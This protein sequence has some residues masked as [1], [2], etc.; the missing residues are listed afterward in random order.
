MAPPLY[1]SRRSRVDQTNSD[2]KYY[3]FYNIKKTKLSARYPFLPKKQIERKIKHLWERASAE[4]RAVLCLTSSG[5][6]SPFKG[7]ILQGL[8]KKKLPLEHIIFNSAPI[9]NSTPT[10][11]MAGSGP[12]RTL[13]SSMKDPWSQTSRKQTLRSSSKKLVSTRRVSF[14]FDQSPLL[15]RPNT[16]SSIKEQKSEER[17]VENKK[18]KKHKSTKDGH[19]RKRELSFEEKQMYEFQD[20]GSKSW[21]HSVGKA[22]VEAGR[23]SHSNPG[24]KDHV[25]APE[26]YNIEISANT[27]IFTDDSQSPTITPEQ[28]LPDTTLNDKSSQNLGKKTKTSIRRNAKSLKNSNRRLQK[29]KDVK[30]NP[31]IGEKGKKDDDP[32]T[33]DDL[34]SSQSDDAGEVPWLVS[35]H[36]DSS[37]DDARDDSSDD[38]DQDAFYDYYHKSSSESSAPTVPSLSQESDDAGPSENNTMFSWNGACFTKKT[39]SLGTDTFDSQLS[40]VSMDAAEVMS[41]SST[42]ASLSPDSPQFIFGLPRK[43]MMSPQG[44]VTPSDIRA[45]SPMLQNQEMHLEDGLMMESPK[46]S[47]CQRDSHPSPDIREDLVPQKRKMRLQDGMLLDSPKT[48]RLQQVSQT[49]PDMIED[50]ALPQKRKM[51]LQDGMKMDSRKSS[52]IQGLVSPTS[53]K[54]QMKGLQ[55]EDMVSMTTARHTKEN[56]KQISPPKTAVSRGDSVV[57]NERKVLVEMNSKPTKPATKTNSTKRNKEDHAPKVQKRTSGRLKNKESLV[58]RSLAKE[59][60]TDEGGNIA[61]GK[62]DYM[63]KSPTTTEQE[64]IFRSDGILCDLFQPNLSSE[65]RSF[66]PQGETE[67]YQSCMDDPV[68]SHLFLEEN[69]FL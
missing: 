40:Q 5:S 12:V 49:S 46:N 35:A 16:R 36:R 9:H 30:N 1:Q 39:S 32:S 25:F 14:N 34:D 6:K 47:R 68:S 10:T 69:F 48:S 21:N 27:N 29:S 22:Q 56:Q 38:Q 17:K 64:E 8:C 65:K 26:H 57:S 13:H 60:C 11:S 28:R 54:R 15:A 44:S 55:G 18:R 7:S 42:E 2:S 66:N 51:R 58:N 53:R 59:G 61:Q 33:V 20:E 62:N 52:R 63:K 67:F 23:S 24:V 45:D 31:S 37:S 3:T 43:M 41:L 50:S 4:K 19:L